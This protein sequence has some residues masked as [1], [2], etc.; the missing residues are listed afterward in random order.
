[1]FNEAIKQE[2]IKLKNKQAVLPPEYL[3]RLFSSTEKYEV[4]N[5][6]DICEFTTEQV[7]DMYK[8]MNLVSFEGILTMNGQLSN[9][10]QMCLQKNLVSDSQNH[11]VEIK[12]PQME[13]C[14]NK[15]ALL[16]RIVTRQQ[17]LD[18]CISLPN[19]SDA[20]IVLGLFEGL[21][22]TKFHELWDARIEDFDE[23]A[24]TMQTPKDKD[25]STRTIKISKQLLY[26][27]IEADQAFDYQ[28]LGNTSRIRKM[29]ENGRIIKDYT[30]NQS[31]DWDLRQ[32]KIYVRMKKLFVYLSE[33][34]EYLSCKSIIESGRIDY[35][36]SKSKEM[37]ITCEEFLHNSKCIKML[38]NQYGTHLYRSAFVS[39][40]HE[41]LS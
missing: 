35:I 5:G 14:V 9:Y 29:Y 26:Y 22:G 21:S 3:E 37:N 7:I 20:F 18:C 36:Q 40:Y 27:A 23:D 16:S 25:G 8:S 30:L 39:K 4:E 13:T 38:E 1:M 2:Y 41:Y 15:V 28:T 11:F 17:I 6:K 24:L 12:R 33:G 34:N 19:P 31:F 32:R 10:T